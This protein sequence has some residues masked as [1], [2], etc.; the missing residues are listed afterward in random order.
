MAEIA[1]ALPFKIDNLG[2][3][4][5]ANTQSKIWADRVRGVIGTTYR[6]RVMRPDF[7]SGIVESLFESAEDR[8]IDFRTQVSEAFREF[9]PDLTLVDVVVT[10]DSSN[11]A[12]EVEI[13]Y[14]LPNEKEIT[15]TI[16]YVQ[17]TG[18]QP[19]LERLTSYQERFNEQ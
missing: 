12:M 7:G 3:I 17:I 14:Q 10:D 11:G 9:L 4:A 15:T 1:I 8:I 19:P 13:I 16:G 2:K 6:E 18:N 5:V